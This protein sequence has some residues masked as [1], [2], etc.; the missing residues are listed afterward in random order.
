MANFTDEPGLIGFRPG[1]LP[2]S[3]FIVNEQVQIRTSGQSYAMYTMDI[4][5]EFQGGIVAIDPSGQQSSEFRYPALES[6]PLENAHL[7]A[8]APGYASLLFQ[9]GD[10]LIVVNPAGER[11][12]NFPTSTAFPRYFSGGYVLTAHRLGVAYELFPGNAETVLKSV[13]EK[14]WMGKVRAFNPDDIQRFELKEFDGVPIETA[15]E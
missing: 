6:K 2:D 13:R 14:G 7:K 11:Y 5:R 12:F 15:T 8:V 10:N 4:K 9:E 3:V 1:E